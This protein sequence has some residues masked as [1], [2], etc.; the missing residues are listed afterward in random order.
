M[1]IK[2]TENLKSFRR[3]KGN[4]QEDL[5]NYLNI[6]IQAISKWERGE[7]FPDISLLPAIAAYYSKS[8][9]ELLGCS[10]IEKAKK[11]E[12]YVAQYNKNGSDGRIE[13]NIQLMK[14]ALKE[15]PNNLTL[16]SNL[17][18]AL[19]FVDKPEYLDECIAVGEE[20]L[21]RSRDDK[22]R[23]G[24]I[25]T[26]VYACNAKKDITKA[27]K[28]AE[29]LPNLYCSKDTV[30]EC[31]LQGDELRKLTQGNIAQHISLIDSSVL[32]MLRSKEYTPQEKIFAYETVDKLYNLFLYDGNYGT[33]HSALYMLWMHI[34]REYAKLQNR[35]KTVSALKKAYNHA[36]EMDHFKS[37]K[38]TTMFADT[39]E[40]S[41]ESFTRNFEKSYVDWLKSLMNEKVFDFI[42]D[43][44]EWN[45]V[46]K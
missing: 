27:K 9:D 10:E 39:G 22:E 33:E 2:I 43:T 4:T 11:I 29:K 35:E 15:F 38:Y 8:V 1:N 18:H 36:Y 45:E 5:A 26:L 28:Y 37:G 21:S 32:W 3:V 46:I 40:Y 41:K 24:T 6:S 20:V 19:F 42:R 16:L 13:E 23:F 25:Q 7:G 31:V 17:C 12:K 34:A 14:T 44:D 30:L